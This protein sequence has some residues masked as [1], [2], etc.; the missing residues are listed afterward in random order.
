[1]IL[2]LIITLLTFTQAQF[3]NCIP[4]GNHKLRWR[5]DTTT[6]SVHLQIQFTNFDTK[7]KG[8]AALGLSD[9]TAPGMSGATIFFLHNNLNTD[10]MD[11]LLATD[12]Q[13]PEPHPDGLSREPRVSY[14]RMHGDFFVDIWKNF[15]YHKDKDFV[16]RDKSQGVLVALNPNDSVGCCPLTFQKHTWAQKVTIN[17][18]ENQ[19]KCFH[20]NPINGARRKSANY[21]ITFVIVL[22]LILW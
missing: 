6:Q 11:T 16:F 13:L 20:Q 22:I 2:I 9:S 4:I 14:L 19:Q 17:F 5:V 10:I 21:V 7:Q 15:T 18:F 12:N 3:D 1:M 8:W